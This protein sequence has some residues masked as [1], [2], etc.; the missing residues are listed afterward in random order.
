MKLLLD[1]H[2]LFW[3]VEET[4]RLGPAALLA[5]QNQSNELLVSAATIWEVSIKVSI[6]KLSLSLPYLGWMKWAISGLNASLLPISLEHADRQST[7]PFHHR[8]PFDRLLA[9]QA[10]SE[11]ITLVSCDE[12]FDQYSLTRLW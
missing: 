9:A 5:V 3:A 1:T 10:L 8:D 12:V 6:G 7:L 2:A 4:T 11:N